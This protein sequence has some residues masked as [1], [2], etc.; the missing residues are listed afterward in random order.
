MANRERRWNRQLIA[1]V[2][3]WSALGLFFAMGA[4]LIASSILEP[5]QESIV[6]C[7]PV[8]ICETVL[9]DRTDR[10]GPT[11]LFILLV[12]AVAALLLAWLIGRTKESSSAAP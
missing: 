10:V 1:R 7:S 5:R 8:G 4:V 3:R 9:V 12:T 11:V 6:N 2:L